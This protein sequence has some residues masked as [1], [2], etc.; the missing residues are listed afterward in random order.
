MN[1]H[2]LTVA[3]RVVKSRG[4]RDRVSHE[5]KTCRAK[6]DSG[7]R[8]VIGEKFSGTDST[9]VAATSANIKKLTKY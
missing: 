2:Y 3:S 9:R 7:R 5:I 8:K 1:F 4:V 6:R